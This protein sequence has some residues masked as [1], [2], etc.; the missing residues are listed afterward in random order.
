VNE[1]SP[2]EMVNEIKKILDAYGIYIRMDQPIDVWVEKVL[3]CMW[4]MMGDL[5]EQ[6]ELLTTLFEEVEND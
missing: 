4:C 1:L 6:D 5:K 3:E 2:L